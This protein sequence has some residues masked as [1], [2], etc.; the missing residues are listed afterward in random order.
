[1]NIEK[2]NQEKDIEVT[3]AD[4]FLKRLKG[5]MFTSKEPKKPLLLVPISR[6]HTCFMRFTIDVLY[7]DKNDRILRK[8]RLKPW[9]LG[10]YVQNTE[11]VLEGRV[12]FADNLGIGDKLN[13]K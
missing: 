9:K 4:S 2:S 5:L 1:M 7:L 8:E 10:I 3:Y 13:F 11:K 6:I 12:G